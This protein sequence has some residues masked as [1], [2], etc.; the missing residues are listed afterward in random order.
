MPSEDE[1][2]AAAHARHNLGG[3]ACLSQSVQVVRVVL[4]R[5][6]EVQR[7]RRHSLG[8][9]RQLH[10]ICEVFCKGN[11]IY[12]GVLPKGSCK[13]R[14]TNTCANARFRRAVP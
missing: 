10:I 2:A 7:R 4:A 1:G 8:P 14:T 11:I 12:P 3:H 6:V 5:A 13:Q 9:Q